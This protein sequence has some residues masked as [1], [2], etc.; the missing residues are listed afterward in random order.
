MSFQGSDILILSR[1]VV[2]AKAI[3]PTSDFV[4][5]GFLAVIY[6]GDN[7]WGTYY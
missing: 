3:Y 1:T 4:G 6:K 7:R 5:R 2:R